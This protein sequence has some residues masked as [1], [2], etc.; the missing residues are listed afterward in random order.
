MGIVTG[1]HTAIKILRIVPFPVRGGWH[2]KT[3]K[4]DGR[5]LGNDSVVYGSR[6]IRENMFFKFV[7]FQYLTQ[8]RAY[9][10]SVAPFVAPP[11]PIPCLR[12]L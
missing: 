5:M 7:S 8:K 1:S 3:E 9:P 12:P 4:D 11:S 2:M 10:Q 6:E